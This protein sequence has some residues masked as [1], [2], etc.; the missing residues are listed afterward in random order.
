M[1]LQFDI[2]LANKY[3]SNSQIARVLTENWV[4]NNSY[5]PS[6]GELPLNEFENNRPVADFYCKKCNEEFELKSKKGKL[7]TIIND[8]AYESMIKRITSDTNPNFFFLT[9]DKNTVNNFLVIPKQFFTP[10]III[11]RKPL[12]ITAKRAG[13]V[14]CNI[15]ISKVPESGRIF[16]VENSKIIEQEKVQIK[17]K[18]TD[19]L[20]SK[21]LEARGW[22]L[23]ILNCVEEIKKQ[24]FT[25]DE[26]YAF[27]NKL[28]IKYP[29]NNH[30]KDKIRQQLQ[31]LRDKGLIEFNGRGNYK[32]IEI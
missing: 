20:R 30:I 11:K 26:L 10:E 28:K 9:Y 23:D 6:C 24:S 7:S 29:N 25:L 18:S 15:D 2:K 32:K 31:F 27:E 1:N 19:F 16:I 5:C 3:N 12:S 4:L 8:G 21:S 14:G 17:L 13:W 22:I